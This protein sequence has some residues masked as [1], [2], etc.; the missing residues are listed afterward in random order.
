MSNRWTSI[1]GWTN[2][3]WTNQSMEKHKKTYP[4]TQF[5]HSTG[6]SYSHRLQWEGDHDV[7]CGYV[8]ET[9]FIVIGPDFHDV[10]SHITDINM[11]MFV[12]ASPDIDI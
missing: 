5:W 2:Q 9:I 1:C 4:A 7:G 11:D 12:I 6:M 3:S 10:G 8:A